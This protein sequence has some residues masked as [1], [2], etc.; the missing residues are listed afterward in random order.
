MADSDNSRTLPRVTQG[1]LHSF[2]A[3]SFPTHPELAARLTGPLDIQNDD[4]AFVIWEQWCAARHRLI[5]SCLRQ[6]GLETDRR[7]LRDFQV[8]RHQPIPT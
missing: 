5:E 2:V 4:L 7:P 1:D 6:Q 3:A 8:L